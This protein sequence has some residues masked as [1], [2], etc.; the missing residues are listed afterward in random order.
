MLINK[1]KNDIIVLVYEHGNYIA[2]YQ[3][4]SNALDVRYI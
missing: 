3:K 2:H 4:I 1:N